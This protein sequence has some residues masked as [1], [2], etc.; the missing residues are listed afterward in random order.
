MLMGRSVVISWPHKE[1]RQLGRKAK[2]K[3]SCG[4]WGLDQNSPQSSATIQTTIT[5]CGYRYLAF[6]FF[7]GRQFLSWNVKTAPPMRVL[8]SFRMV[9]HVFCGTL[10]VHKCINQLFYKWGWHFGR[11][12]FLLLYC[13]IHHPGG[14]LSWCY[15]KTK[16]KKQLCYE[17]IHKKIY[18]AQ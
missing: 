6:E 9:C 18:W 8:P 2:P 13:H 1:Y 5:V 4:R 11:F 15:K 3:R 14:S 17:K 12:L 10:S 7:A 16:R